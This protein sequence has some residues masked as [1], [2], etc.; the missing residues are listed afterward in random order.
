M[1]ISRAPAD[2]TSQITG[3]GLAPRV[4]VASASPRDYRADD[5]ARVQDLARRSL[6]FGHHV[7]FWVE[8][9]WWLNNADAGPDRLSW[10]DSW[11]LP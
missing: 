7:G 1:S 4:L 11:P 9:N 10:T 2:T 8:G 5:L 3:Q 6:D